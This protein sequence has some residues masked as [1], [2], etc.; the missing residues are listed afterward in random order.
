MAQQLKRIVRAE[1]PNVLIEDLKVFLDKEGDSIDL[2]GPD[3]TGKP[4]RTLEAVC[5]SISLDTLLSLGHLTLWDENGVQLTGTTMLQATNLATMVNGSGGTTITGLKT[6]SINVPNGSDNVSVVFDVAFDDENYSILGTLKNDDDTEPSIYSHVI[7]AKS[8]YGFTVL[9][10]GE[11]DS[12]NYY[13]E[14]AAAS[15]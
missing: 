11:M 5:R 1:L 7:D 14:W 4:M 12:V 6:G 8:K 2:I 9:F 15:E 13:F 3:V 10:I